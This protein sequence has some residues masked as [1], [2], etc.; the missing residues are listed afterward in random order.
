MEDWLHQ[1]S[2]PRLIKNLLAYLLTNAPEAECE[3]F[4]STVSRRNK[5]RILSYL[6]IIQR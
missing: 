5:G 3:S 6:M 1:M 4:I 2:K